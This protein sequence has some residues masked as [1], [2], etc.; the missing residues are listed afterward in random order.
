MRTSAPSA[1][2]GCRSRRQGEAD[3]DAADASRGRDGEG[4][5]A[6]VIKKKAIWCD[7]LRESSQT[8]HETEYAA[9]F[10]GKT[11]ILIFLH[12]QSPKV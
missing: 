1:G 12:S 5:E 9:A 11:N 3:P 4:V 8:H 6:E 2:V 10:Q 7:C